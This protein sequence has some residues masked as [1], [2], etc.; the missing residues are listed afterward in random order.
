[1]LPIKDPHSPGELQSLLQRPSWFE[2]LFFATSL[3][4][5]ELLTPE[6]SGIAG[7][8]ALLSSQNLQ[9]DLWES[10][11]EHIPFSLAKSN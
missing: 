9:K 5:P 6:S 1:M 10:P 11:I 7:C 2:K 8:K 4:P 3:Q